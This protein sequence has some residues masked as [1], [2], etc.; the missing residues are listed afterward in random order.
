MKYLLSLV[1]FMKLVFCPTY[2]VPSLPRYLEP[3][4][5]LLHINC[6]ATGESF[7]VIL[8]FCICLCLPDCHF[9]A[10]ILYAGL[11]SYS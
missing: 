2:K 9:L 10:K 4:S 1:R 3:L 7:I 11:V 6:A 8:L 5:H